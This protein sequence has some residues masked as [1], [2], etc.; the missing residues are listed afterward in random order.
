MT[1]V[2]RHLAVCY[3]LSGVPAGKRKN[4]FFHVVEHVPFQ[5]PVLSDEA[6]L[7]GSFRCNADETVEGWRDGERR[8]MTLVYAPLV[9]RDTHPVSLKVLEDDSDREAVRLL[10]TEFQVTLDPWRSAPP[11]S[12]PVAFG[13]LPRIRSIEASDRDRAIA[14]RQK[15][16]LEHCVVKDDALLCDLV[17]PVFSTYAGLP[18]VRD[19]VLAMRTDYFPQMESP[20]NLFFSLSRV[21]SSRAG[22]IRNA[23][24]TDWDFPDFEMLASRAIGALLSYGAGD[25]RLFPDLADAARL[26]AAGRGSPLNEA[27]RAELSRLLA[28]VGKTIE[29]IHRSGSDRNSSMAEYE[30]IFDY[31][32]QVT[33]Y[34]Y[35][36]DNAP[37]EDISPIRMGI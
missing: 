18:F 9:A 29:A 17:R 28:N 34:G 26:A 35:M 21:E 2:T 25:S 16:L 33:D 24:G 10:Q 4:T 13:S 8:L 15:F 32:Q 14:A 7:V 31:L 20:Q 23:F 22:E 11:D 1:T 19:R 30:V 5:I 6:A 36:G 37:A 12:S 27:G 3:Y